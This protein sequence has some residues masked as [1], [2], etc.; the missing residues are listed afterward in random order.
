MVR[1][2]LGTPGGGYLEVV[3]AAG[4]NWPR[5]W[6]GEGEGSGG[7]T[8]EVEGCYGFWVRWWEARCGGG[9]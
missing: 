4:M 7:L 2:R 8:W 9:T 5:L 1:G 6:V 3:V